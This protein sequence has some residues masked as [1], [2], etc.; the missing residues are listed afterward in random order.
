MESALHEFTVRMAGHG[1][2]VSGTLMKFDRA[3]ALEQ[4]QLGHTLA[5]A[6]LREMS[7]LLFRWFERRQ[8]VAVARA[9]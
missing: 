5:D 2:S 8:P 9:A 4:L 1:F 6:K 3:Y 7:M